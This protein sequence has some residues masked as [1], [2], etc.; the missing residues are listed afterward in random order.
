[1]FKVLKR[2]GSLQ[3]FNKGKI[4]D[5]VVHA[6]ASYEDAVSVANSVEAWL[7]SVSSDNVIDHNRIRAKVLDLL[8]EIDSQLVEN[9]EGY[10]K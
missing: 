1:M 2:N 9:F 4:V 3:D 7:P 5:V 6:G 8:S 10:K